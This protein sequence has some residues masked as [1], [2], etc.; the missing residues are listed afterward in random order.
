MSK[1]KR[2]YYQWKELLRDTKIL[3][4]KLK[5]HRFDFIVAISRGGLIPATI[6]AYLLKIK[7]VQVIGFSHYRGDQIQK[8]L[9]C[10]VPL[11]SDIKNSKIL[12]IDD[13]V[14][15]G[16]TMKRAYTILKKR[17]NKI[18]M[19]TLHYKGIKNPVIKP[20]YYIKDIGN[21]WLVYPWEP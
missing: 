19:A 9:H 17:K 7:K 8:R 10:L 16:L 21:V 18:I 4:R 1:I 3:A 20:D 15:S 2:K 13:I 12:L 5:K 6:L 11:S 14:D